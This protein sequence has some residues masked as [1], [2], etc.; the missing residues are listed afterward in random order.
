MYK[1]IYYKDGIIFQIYYLK[2]LSIKRTTNQ[3][4]LSGILSKVNV[5]IDINKRKR[6]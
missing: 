6:I 3:I 5:S 4:K 2:L 1:I